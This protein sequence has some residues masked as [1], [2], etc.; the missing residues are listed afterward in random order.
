MS[1][2]FTMPDRAS[3]CNVNRNNIRDGDKLQLQGVSVESSL[4]MCRRWWRKP[5]KV[6][7]SCSLHLR[8][9]LVIR[10]RSGC[11]RIMKAAKAKD[12]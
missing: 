1:V 12:M 8:C 3:I 11:S 10:A 7:F 2:F 4:P 6:L 9:S 5:P